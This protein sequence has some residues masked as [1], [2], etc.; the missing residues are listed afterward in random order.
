MKIKGLLFWT[1]ILWLA[2]HPQ[3]AW[4]E[5]RADLPIQSD[6]AVLM[7]AKSGTVLYEKNGHKK[8]YPASITKIAT[9]IYAIEKGNLSDTVE[10]SERATQVDGTRVYL[11]PGEKMTLEQLITGMVINSG[12]DAAEAIAEYLD[13]SVEHFSANL[14]RFLTEKTGVINTHFTNPHGLYDPGHYTTAYDMARITRYAMENGKFR[15]IFGLKEYPWNGK[16]WKTILHT[17]HRLLKGEFPA[18]GITGGKTGFVNESGHTL[19]TTAEKDGMALIAVTMNTPY[20]N[21]PY[22]DTLKM[23]DYGFQNF[24][25][26]KVTGQTLFP[27]ENGEYFLPH[28]VYYVLP[29]G[30][31]AETEVDRSG[32][33]LIK[34]ADGT[35]LQAAPLEKLKPAGR[36]KIEKGPEEHREPTSWNGMSIFSGLLLLFTFIF[37]S[38]L[39][40]KL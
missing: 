27:A 15:R 23:L 14:N 22:T 10:I 17:H 18:E 34:S 19:V 40:L 9:A 8:E 30:E 39:L 16:G 35:I 5:E 29:K 24:T 21:V 33:L 7:E 38:R 6:S 11:E 20:K 37:G 13:G 36:G 26:E 28:D 3:A 12:N 25:V 32:N 2:F 31:R 4:G 1:P